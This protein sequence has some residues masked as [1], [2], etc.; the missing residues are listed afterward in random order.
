MPNKA[1][2]KI[3]LN[4]VDESVLVKRFNLSPRLAKRIIA[5]RPYQSVDQLTRVWGIDPETLQQ[6]LPQVTVVGEPG[7]PVEAREKPVSTLPAVE[8]APPAGQ[9]SRPTGAAPEEAPEAVLPREETPA[10]LAQK[11]KIDWKINLA[12][13]LILLIGAYFRFSGLNWDD[14]H[15]QH[16]DERFITMVTDQIRGVSGI[17]AYFDT[18]KSTLNPLNFGSYTYGMLP[19]FF[20]RMIAEWVNMANYDKITLVGRA[21]SGLFDLA[22][23]LMLFLL[24]ARLY[25]RQVGLVA[26]ALASAAVLPIQLSHFYAVDSFSTVFVIACFYFGLSAV[27][28]HHPQGRVERSNLIYFAIFGVMVGLAGACKVNTLPVFGVI[29]L[30]GAIYLASLWKKRAFRPA[31][32]R[33]LQGWGLALLAAFLTF[34][35]F[36]PYA[37]SGP[38]FLGIEINPQW[39]KVIQEVT[40]QVAGKSEWPPNHHWTNRPPTY[41]WTNMVQWGMGLPLGLAGWLGLAWAAWQSWKGDWRRHILPMVWVVG[42]FLWQNAQFWR[43]MRYFMPIYPF[44]IL[45]AAWA[46]VE[47]YDRTQESRARLR[48]NGRNLALQLRSWRSVWQGAAALLAVG[49]VL[50]GTFAYAFAFTRIYTRPITRIAASEWMLENI[51]GPLNVVVQGPDRTLSYPIAVFNQQVVLPET[52]TTIPFRALSDGSTAQI[53]TTRVRPVGAY[54]YIRIARDSDG[55]DIL[56]EGRLAYVPDDP[57]DP[58]KINEVTFGDVNLNSG[59]TYYLLYTVNLGGELNTASMAL[60][61]E[62]ADEAALPLDWSID[63]PSSGE[64]TGSLTLKPAANFRLNRLVFNVTRFT[65]TPV[66][67]IIQITLAKNDEGRDPLAVA[68]QTLKFDRL[69][70]E[71]APSFDFPRVQLKKDE[72]YYV[73]YQSI[74]GGPLAFYGDNLAL[75]TSWDDALPLGVNGYD[76]LGGIYSPLNLELYEPDTAAKRDAMIDILNRSNYLVLPSNRA[77]DAMPRLPLRYP[78]TLKYYQALFGCDCSGDALENRAYGLQPPFHS[79]LGFDLVA[80][81]TSRPNI[82]PLTIPDESADESFTVY[83]HPKVLIFKKSPNFS[84]D[85]VKTLLFSVDLDQIIFQTPMGYTQV[86]TAMQLPPDRLA[87]QANGGTWSEIFDRASLLNA[88]PAAGAVVWYLFLLLMGWAIFPAV[89]FALPGLPD[90]GYTLVRV[91]GLITVA[92][93]GW[94]LGSLKLL[95]FTRSTL[96]V[97]FLAVVF[98]CLWLAYRQRSAFLNYLRSHWKHILGT[99]FL[100]LALFL[101]SLSIRLGNPDLWNPWLG[102][103]KPMDFA[104][105]NATLKAVYFPPEHPWFSGHYINYYYYGYVLAAIPTKLLGI[106]PSIAYNLVLPSWFAMTG[107]GIFGIAY[108]LVSALRRTP[109]SEIQASSGRFNLRYSLFSVKGLPYTAGVLTV[110]AVLFFGNF[111]VVRELWNYLP[112]VSMPGVEI[113]SPLERLDGVIAGAGQILSGKAD[114]PGNKGRWYFDPSRPILHDGPDTPIAE[115]PYF[116]YL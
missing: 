79:P 64:L 10:P 102:G 94:I 114:L 108:N 46:I 16:P 51:P 30:A 106:L 107:V 83:D 70:Q 43:Y 75:E 13:V 14:N 63:H 24:G 59:E 17:G 56:A 49:V 103:E 11:P 71:V 33:I 41:A 101:F 69:D 4:T 95:A 55:K 29:L 50:L 80:T 1:L 2:P 39:L 45:F 34:R 104:F 105:F 86:P 52:T 20:T 7:Q 35:I 22:A 26:A 92:W 73:M 37:F 78:M 85:L 58:K 88:S 90:R 74:S 84:I 8:P 112:E 47:L 3:D 36:Q 61:N 72:T 65:F 66:S 57:I 28:I 62:N 116:T 67:N 93:L 100:F 31:L 40:D 99:E 5:L 97:C 111:F 98:L 115:F 68:T 42:Y 110:I 82:G 89:Y 48:E 18:A 19:L 9:A 76:P 81:F 91:A 109:K 96:F 15:H 6:M 44:L 77:Y 21:L 32:E 38:G 27:P 12:L 53:T 25:N 60:R 54:F 113:K 87:A 23:V